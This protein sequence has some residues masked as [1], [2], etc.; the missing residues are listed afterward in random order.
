MPKLILTRG[1]PGSGK[2]TWAK[3]LVAANPDVVRVNRDNLRF[4]HYGKY[5][6][7]KKQE[8][9][10]TKI[11]QSRVREALSSGKSVVVDDTNLSPMAVGGWH[12]MA[13]DYDGK[14]QLEFKDFNVSPEECI[15]RDSKRRAEGKR[16]T[17]ADVINRFA[18]NAIGRDGKLK[19]V[20]AYIREPIPVPPP[21]HKRPNAVIYDMDGTLCDVRP[22]RHHVRAEEGKSRNF[23]AFHVESE[24][25]PPNIHVLEMAKETKELGLSVVIVTAREERYRAL[26]DRWLKKHGV[27]YD[28]LITRPYG[29]QRP[30][31]E[32][33]KDILAQVSKYYR[34][35][36]AVDDNPNVLTLWREHGIAVTEVPGF[37]DPVEDPTASFPPIPIDSPI[38]GGRCLKC[39]KQMKKT[40]GVLGPICATQSN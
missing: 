20:P 1:L 14:V 33:K 17:G 36:H 38:K 5:V 26:T 23:H 30:D 22:V 29:D 3:E 18:A 25:C 9:E 35:V 13:Q 24:F 34:V 32:T 4:E 11:Q 10:I 16:G 15:R 27:E 12:K 28:T 40:E 19:P 8:R 21:A 37:E 2:S 31:Y 6:I 39:N 7:S